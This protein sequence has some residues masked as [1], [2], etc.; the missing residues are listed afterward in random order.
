MREKKESSRPVLPGTKLYTSDP[1]P[2]QPAYIANKIRPFYKRLIA[3]VII[4][5][6]FSFMKFQERITNVGASP[7]SD[8]SS[9][10]QPLN[11]T[12]LTQ[13]HYEPLC[14]CHT[15]WHKH[16]KVNYI[17]LSPGYVKNY[18]WNVIN[19]YSPWGTRNCPCRDDF[20]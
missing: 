17:V 19:Y 16:H 11:S 3:F 18:L 8:P 5:S 12:H 14:P 1:N 6:G 13:T 7:Q 15:I 4:S 10:D 20:G 2:L 9:F